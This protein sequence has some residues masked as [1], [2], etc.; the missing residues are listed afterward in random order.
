MSVFRFFFEV[1]SYAH[2][3]LYW[4]GKKKEQHLGH[5]ATC[6]ELCWEGK[7][8]EQLGAHSMQRALLGRKEEGA[9][10]GAQHSKQHA[11]QL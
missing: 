8:K 2:S 5:T 4:E 11:Q 7:K 9:A 3:A 10:W 6:K 1:I